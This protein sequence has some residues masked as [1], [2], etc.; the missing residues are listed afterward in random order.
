MNKD[1]IIEKLKEIK[2]PGYNRDIISFGIVKNLKLSDNQLILNLNLNAE[3][4]IIQQI[5]A[6]INSH[7]N[8]HF[9]NLDLI[10][11]V[12]PVQNTQ[13]NIMVIL[14]P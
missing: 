4:N 8:Q 9:N 5:K 7:L 13:N 6:S 3:D 10:I 2:Y 12:I 1:D 11:N 14:K